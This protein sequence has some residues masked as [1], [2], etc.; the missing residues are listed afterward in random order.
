MAVSTTSGRLMPST[1]RAYWMSKRAIHGR[2]ATQ[3]YGL[4]RPRCGLVSGVAG[5]LIGT[6][7]EARVNGVA[8]LAV[9]VEMAVEQVVVPDDDAQRDRERAGGAEERPPPHRLDPLRAGNASNPT[10]K[11]AGRKTSSDNQIR[12]DS[13]IPW[14]FDSSRFQSS[15]LCSSSLARRAN[16]PTSP[17]ATLA[18]RA[19]EAPSGPFITV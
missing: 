10:A 11:I 13:G 8:R 3:S 14:P 5:G 1:P 15:K 4:Q 17:A 7:I 19:S 18:R 9:G 16:N 6:G 2:R 12:S